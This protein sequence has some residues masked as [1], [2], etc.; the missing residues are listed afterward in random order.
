[1]EHEREENLK[2]ELEK[3]KDLFSSEK[4]LPN[5]VV[6]D[7]ELALMNVIEVVFPNLTHL[8]CSFHISKN[9]SM[10]CKKYVKSKRHEF[11]M[12]LWNNIMYANI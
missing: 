8:L 3:L 6:T 4:L 1:M 9:I 5:V 10:K 12:D 11:L 2:W 7:Q